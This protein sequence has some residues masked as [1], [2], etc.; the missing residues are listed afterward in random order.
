MRIINNDRNNEV[1]LSLRDLINLEEWQKIQ[2]NFSGL[3]DIGIRVVDPD[4]ELLTSP[5]G[6]LRLCTQL[7]RDS[8]K[9]EVLCGS[10]LPAFLGGKGFVDKNLNF[11]CHAGL[12]NFI[13]PIKLR[14]ARL[15]GYIILGPV[16]LVMRREKEEYRKI[17]E[18]LNL[19]LEDFWSAILEIKVTSLHGM[20]SMVELVDD[21][22]EYI[23]NLA[24]RKIIKERKEM[25]AADLSKLR[26]ILDV[27]LDV[28]FEVSQADIGSVMFFDDIQKIL[29]IRASKGIPDEI[30]RDTKVKLGEGISGIAAQ[31]GK[32]F[33][34]NEDFKDNR[35]RPYL[36][37]PYLSSSMILPIKAENRIVGVINLGTMKTSPVKFDLD[38]MQIMNRLIDLVGVAISP[39]K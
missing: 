29:T 15:L 7:L 10:C 9:K 23:V 20:Q 22:C 19:D 28:A 14:D 25:M 30:A 26:K 17:A 2:N 18:E 36:N 11:I 24:Y 13:V 5:S 4:G 39:A 27:L 3:M 37:R 16:I 21:I 32:S 1:E 8:G 6:E 34:I 33:L 38:N 31:D 12:N 35:I